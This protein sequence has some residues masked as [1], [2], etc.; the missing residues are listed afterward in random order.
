M[1][2]GTFGGD[3]CHK[4]DRVRIVQI[5]YVYFKDH[6]CGYWTCHVCKHLNWL[7]KE[8]MNGRT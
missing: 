3:Y 8:L 6:V 2:T 7:K 5:E 1:T 4:C